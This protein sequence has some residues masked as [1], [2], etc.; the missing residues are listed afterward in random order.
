MRAAR[1]AGRV[2]AGR[3]AGEVEITYAGH[4]TYFIDT[5]GGLRIATDYSG[6]YQAGGCPMSS[7]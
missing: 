6:A 1:D 2:P 4:S 5:P 7:P 3:Q